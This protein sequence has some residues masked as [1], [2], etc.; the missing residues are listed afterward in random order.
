[1]RKQLKEATDPE[2]QKRLETRIASMERT[3]EALEKAITA[4][5]EREKKPGT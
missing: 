3:R 1:V 2:Q 4:A 5:A